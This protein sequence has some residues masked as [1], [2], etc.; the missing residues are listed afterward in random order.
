MPLENIKLR[1]IIKVE[2]IPEK[3]NAKAKGSRLIF[4]SKNSSSKKDKTIRIDR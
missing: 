2:I 3:N 1:D 4:S